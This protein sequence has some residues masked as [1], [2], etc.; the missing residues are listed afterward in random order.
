MLDALIDRRH[1]RS[2]DFHQRTIVW[3]VYYRQIYRYGKS[4]PYVRTFL[5]DVVLKGLILPCFPDPNIYKRLH[6]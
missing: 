6:P 2:V 1:I 3:P 4:E 5:S